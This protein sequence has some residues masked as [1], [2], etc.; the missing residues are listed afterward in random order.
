MLD[1]CNVR[2]LLNRRKKFNIEASFHGIKALISLS[3]VVLTFDP[4]Q[5]AKAFVDLIGVQGLKLYL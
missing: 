2:L 3:T 1:A 5:A 4:V